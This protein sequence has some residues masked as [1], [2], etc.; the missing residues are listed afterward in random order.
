MLLFMAVSTTL[1]LRLSDIEPS[2]RLTDLNIYHPLSSPS[3]G[4]GNRSSFIHAWYLRPK[5]SQ[6]GS[7]KYVF[8]GGTLLRSCPKNPPNITYFAVQE[9]EISK[10]CNFDFIAEWGSFILLLGDL[11]SSGFL[12]FYQDQDRESHWRLRKWSLRFIEICSIFVLGCWVFTFLILA[13]SQNSDWTTKF[14]FHSH[15]ASFSPP[16]A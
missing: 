13:S 1:E 8:I 3:R 5:K 9:E 14:W 4:C 7:M 2:M 10:R 16:S 11:K 6:D 15:S 12:H